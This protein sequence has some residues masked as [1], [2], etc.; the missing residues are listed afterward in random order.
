[1]HINQGG[2]GSVGKKEGATMGEP[3][4]FLRWREKKECV[5]KYISQ[6]AAMGGSLILSDLTA[7]GEPLIQFNC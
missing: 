2:C 5:L 1:M 6:L 7:K 3:I 4:T